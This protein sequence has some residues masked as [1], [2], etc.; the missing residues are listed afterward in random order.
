MKIKVLLGLTL[1]L[2]LINALV[3]LA[4]LFHTEMTHEMALNLFFTTVAL[5]AVMAVWIWIK[6]R[7]ASILDDYL[8]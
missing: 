5:I 1:S 3:C 2:V 6:V 7:Q 8:F 4:D